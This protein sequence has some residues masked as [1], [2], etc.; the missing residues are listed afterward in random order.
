M[1]SDAP[2]GGRTQAGMLVVPW[3]AT[4]YPVYIGFAGDKIETSMDWFE[5]YIVALYQDQKPRECRW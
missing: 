3:E 2:A 4:F 5:V 1:V